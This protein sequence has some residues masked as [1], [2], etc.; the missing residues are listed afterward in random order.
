M[1][2]SHVTMEEVNMLQ[3]YDRVLQLQFYMGFK[4]QGRSSN[5][6]FYCLRHSCNILL[7]KT[8]LVL[9]FLK[10]YDRSREYK[11]KTTTNRKGNKKFC[12]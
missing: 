1:E 11:K 7:K 9:E 8:D 12:W 2:R 6:S 5:F 3:L 4:G 10:C